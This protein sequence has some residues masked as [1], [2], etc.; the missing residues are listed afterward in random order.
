MKTFNEEQRG[1]VER[2]GENGELLAWFSQKDF[3]GDGRAGH[4]FPGT[5]SMESLLKTANV[6][7]YLRQT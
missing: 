3:P 4:I 1:K 5:T 2:K 6:F 7:I